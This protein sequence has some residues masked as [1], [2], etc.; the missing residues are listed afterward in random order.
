MSRLPDDP[1]RP[2]RTRRGLKL[3]GL[4]VL[5]LAPA[6]ALSR[7]GVTATG[8]PALPSLPIAG[9]ETADGVLLGLQAVLRLAAVALNALGS[10]PPFLHSLP[11][12][13]QLAL[14]AVLAGGAAMLAGSALIALAAA[15]TLLR[16]A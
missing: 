16:R 13:G 15:G 11:T 5:G 4:A 9:P 2:S 3:A 6:L 8:L 14:S 1:P 7:A 10:V 12:T